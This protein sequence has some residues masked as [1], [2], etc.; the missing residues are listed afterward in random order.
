[1]QLSK[2]LETIAACIPQNAIIADI[3]TDHACLP[4]YLVQKGVC[5]R[6][7][8]GDLNTGPVK[9][10]RNMVKSRGLENRIEIRQGDGLEILKPGEVDVVIMA[11]MGGELMARLLAEGRDKIKSVQRLLLQPN[12]NAWNVRSWLAENGWGIIDE[13]LVK[14][15]GKFYPVIISEQ[16]RGLFAADSLSLEVG[17]FLLQ[18][19]GPL[20]KELLEQKSENYAAILEGLSKSKDPSLSRKKKVIK[21]LL[22][23]IKGELERGC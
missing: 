18:K 3:G 21:E 16:G 9:S 14:E 20:V 1:M 19:G 11:G 23:G 4:V 5:P 6:A 17:P 12:N 8:A 7:V 2:R 10:A 15:R 22:Q 13:H